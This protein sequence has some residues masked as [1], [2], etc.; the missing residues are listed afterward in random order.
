MRANRFGTDPSAPRCEARP[1]TSRLRTPTLRLAQ[2]T[3]CAVVLLLLAPLPARALIIEVPNQQADLQKAIDA[4]SK[5]VDP[6]N[7]VYLTQTPFY[8]NATI[9]ISDPNLNGSHHLTIRPK[10]GIPTLPRVEIINQDPN[11]WLLSASS[12]TGVTIQDLDLL[13]D[14]TNL[15]DLVSLSMCTSLTVERCRLGY[16]NVSLGGSHLEMVTI[17]YPTHVVIRNCMFFSV[18]PAEFDVALHAAA[19]GDPMNSLYLYNNDFSDY[20]KVGVRSDGTGPPNALIVLR[21]NV[22]V[23][24]AGI[25]PEPVAYSSGAQ[26]IMRVRTSYNTAFA[27]AGSAEALDVGAQSIAGSSQADFLQL[28]PSASEEN[29][30]FVTRAWDATP[31]A[32]NHDFYHLIGTAGLH[33]PPSRYGVTVQNGSPSPEDEAVT[34][35]IDDQARPSL[36]SLPHTDRGADQLDSE[37]AAASATA[38]SPETRLWVAPRHNPS[39]A[40]EL[41][42]ASREGGELVAEVFDAGGRLLWRSRRTVST[43]GTG[44]LEGPAALSAGLA[45]YRVRLLVN[46]GAVSEARGRMVLLR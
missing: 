24:S 6:D 23:N 17:V 31:G 26:L 12:V 36:G 4:A 21:N 32:L 3:L 13:R 42:F 27:S 25:S 5:S 44:L 15:S 18:M 8:W 20:G 29:G 34:N 30:D 41:S 11:S 39:R 37:T 38:I 46:S 43:G 7:Y 40:I 1:T 35:D 33:S 10:P 28:I 2:V 9:S 16:V 14:V 45:F 19:M 22:A